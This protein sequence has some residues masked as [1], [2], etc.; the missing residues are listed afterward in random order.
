LVK[1]AKIRQ[2]FFRLKNKHPRGETVNPYITLFMIVSLLTSLIGPAHI[3]PNSFPIQSNNSITS[4]TVSDV[5]E[6]PTLDWPYP[7]PGETPTDEPIT[8]ATT[9]PPTAT[10]TLTPTEGQP[11]PPPGETQTAEPTETVTPTSPPTVTLTPTATSTVV[12]PPIPQ[13]IT[14]SFA[15]HHYKPGEIILIDWKID[16]PEGNTPGA[17]WKIQLNLPAGWEPVDITLGTFDPQTN[18]LVIPITLLHGKVSLTTDQNSGNE[19]NSCDF[20]R[21]RNAINGHIAARPG[22]IFC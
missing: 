6:T 20:I 8:T 22:S 10:P 15:A 14:L 2:R 11:Y 5:T 7:P 9:L 19:K 21:W 3:S 18:Q 17:N 13:G 16:T 12:I 1:I 4:A